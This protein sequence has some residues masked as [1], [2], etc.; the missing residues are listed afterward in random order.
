[1]GWVVRNQEPMLVPNFDQ[2][3][4]SLGYYADGEEANIKAFMAW[5]IPGGGVLCVDSKRQ[6]SFS[7]KDHKI[8]QLFAGLVARQQLQRAKDVHVGEIPRYFAQL[9]MV[10]DLRFRFRRWSVFLQHYLQIMSDATGFEYCAFASVHTPGESYAVEGESHP[11]VLQG[12]T[13][14]VLPMGTGSIAGW[15]FHNDQEIINEDMGSELTSSRLFGKVGQ[16]PAFR[17]IICMPVMVNKS[18]R[19]ILCLAHGEPRNIDESMRSFLRQ[20]VDHL[21]LFLENLYLRNRLRGMLSKAHVHTQ[22][23]GSHNSSYGENSARA[24]R[25]DV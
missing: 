2:Q 13:A 23:M 25:E 16:C 5:P 8:L 3:Q 19:G 20:S 11:L 14:L 6:Y 21:A 12:E 7:D 17:A 10:Q 1:M 9:G 24:D 22:P 18:T 4:S 15:V